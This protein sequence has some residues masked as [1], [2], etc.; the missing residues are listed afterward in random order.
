MPQPRLR[1]VP[2]TPSPRAQASQ[3]RPERSDPAAPDLQVEGLEEAASDLLPLLVRYHRELASE[4][5]PPLDPDWQA[6]L[7]G[8]ALGQVMLVT[9][10]HEGVLVGF[11]LSVLYTHCF[12]RTVAHAQTHEWLD[13]AYRVGPFGLEFLK[14]N[15]EMLREKGAKRAYIATGNERVGKVYERAG[16]RFE[17]A[18]YVRTFA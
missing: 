16:Y 13:P 8:A 3:G 2:S 9:A 7:R 15:A 14:F 12:H 18:A 11:A 5:T 17:E 6:L 4:E 1:V 10:R